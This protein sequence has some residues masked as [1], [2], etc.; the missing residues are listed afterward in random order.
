MESYK[1]DLQSLFQYQ[2]YKKYDGG[3]FI[4][5]K[6]GIDSQGNKIP[7]IVKRSEEPDLQST[8]LCNKD[9]SEILRYIRLDIDFDKSRFE[10][11]NSENTCLSWEA[12]QNTLSKFPQIFEAIEYVTKSTSGKGFHILIGLS[13]LPLDGR[14]YG[15][16][17]N[18]RQLQQLL[19]EVFNELGIGADP[20]GAGLKQD[21]CTYRK[22]KGIVYHNELLT[23]RIEKESQKPSYINE[24]GIKIVNN[25]EP[26][27]TNLLTYVKSVY[28]ELEINY[29]LYPDIRVERCLSKL[30]LYLMGAYQPKIF[31]KRSLTL[32]GNFKK[33]VVKFP[34]VSP[35]EHI[36]LEKDEIFKIMGTSSR[37]ALRYFKMPE[38]NK[39]FNFEL[40]TDDTIKISCKYNKNVLKQIERANKVL[41]SNEI[42]TNVKLKLIEPYLVQ[43]GERN[44]AIVNWAIAYKWNGY[45]EY[46]TLEKI[47]LRVKQIPASETSR[48]C[49]DL[50][51]KCTVHSIFSNR[52]ELFGIKKVNLPKWLEDDKYFIKSKNFSFI[53]YCLNM[54]PLFFSRSVAPCGN[55]WHQNVKR[56]PNKVFVINRGKN[57]GL[58]VICFESFRKKKEVGIAFQALT[59]PLKI[60][61]VSFNQRIGF[62]VQDKLQLCLIKNRHYKLGPVLHALSKILKRQVLYSDIVHMRKNTKLYNSLAHM[63]YDNDIFALH[64]QQICGNRPSKVEN[65]AVYF[66]KRAK[67][68]GM[69][70]EEYM[71]KIRKPD[72]IIDKKNRDTEIYF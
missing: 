28:E 52:K 67:T 13:P 5:K 54:R 39:L 57:G 63:L 15:A 42:Q 45:S 59:R 69:T 61:A 64:A 32:T 62:F 18:A 50:Q 11:R 38:F 16:Q 7:R 53:E 41:A 47:K 6:W 3:R 48:S 34:Y 72:D 23:K 27:L 2:S 43:D 65:M 29:R 71:S 36:E 46:E 68:L 30:F 49:K 4:Y 70:Y 40:T 37:T 10:L 21:F 66:E 19:I 58:N 20:S 24:N 12:I 17:I 26:F 22:V 8:Y 14:T 56:C 55:R 9:R 35:H 25:K 31:E 33:S 60:H 51:L 44:L 1:I